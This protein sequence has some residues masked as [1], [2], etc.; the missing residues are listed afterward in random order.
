MLSVEG[1][2]AAT[3]A[4]EN[5]SLTVD[6]KVRVVDRRA[7][8]GDHASIAV[9]PLIVVVGRGFAACEELAPGD[10]LADA[11]GVVVGRTKSLADFESV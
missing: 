9:A 8:E 11:L 2:A 7:E 10:Q 6:S 4:V 1:A 5:V 3:D